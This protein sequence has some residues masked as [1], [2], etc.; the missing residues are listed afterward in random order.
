MILLLFGFGRTISHSLELFLNQEFDIGPL[1][2]HIR[3]P[4]ALLAAVSGGQLWLCEITRT[5]YLA[6]KN[7][8]IREQA[9][10]N[11]NTMSSSG[12]LSF[13]LFVKLPIEL[14]NIIWQITLSVPRAISGE[15]C[16]REWWFGR[17][18]YFLTPVALQVSHNSRS[19]AKKALTRTSPDSGRVYI[20]L[21]LLFPS[22]PSLA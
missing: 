21:S 6:T 4:H 7:R 1:E 13:T 9:K 3:L 20:P 10:A 14:Q 17:I 18:K 12:D 8:V 15:D 11:L 5:W 16:F 2:G 19:L 22:L